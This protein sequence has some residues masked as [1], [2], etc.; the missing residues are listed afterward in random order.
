MARTKFVLILLIVLIYAFR[1]WQTTGCK[2]FIDYSFIPLSVKINVE[3]QTA[4]D[5]GIN[6]TVARF[7]HNKVSV[8]IYESSKTYLSTFSPKLLFETLGPVGVVLL[9]FGIY[10]ISQKKSF[11]GV[12]HF[13]GV[14]T[15][16]L[17]AIIFSFPKL[18]FYVLT[19]SRYSFSL[20]GINKAAKSTLHVSILLALVY[21]TFW[22]FIFNWQ[23][24]SVCNNI[25][26]N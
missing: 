19:L 21:L 26:F 12:I 7:F 24:K 13:L 23:M 1:L 16:P 5:T 20:W 25:F 4:T 18:E 8:G 10:E 6:R 22:Y 15:I 3:S 14:L 9:I 2:Q 11:L 17:F